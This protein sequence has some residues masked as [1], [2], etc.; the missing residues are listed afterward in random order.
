M[1]MDRLSVRTGI[2][3]IAGAVIAAIDSYTFGGEISPIVIVLMLLIGAFAAG[4]AWGR[5]GWV[6]AL[7]MWIGVPMTHI[8]KHLLGLS[9][10]LQPNT[11]A[12]IL[13]LAVFTLLFVTVGVAGGVLIHNVNARPNRSY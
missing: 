12:S 2:G 3:F 1:R 6:A 10:T 8:L 13:M 7:A 5:R 9:D 4:L 11:Y